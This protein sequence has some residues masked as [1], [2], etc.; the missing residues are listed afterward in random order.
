[1]LPHL[2]VIWDIIIYNLPM[3]QVTYF[4]FF[5]CGVN[6]NK[7]FLPMGVSNSP[8]IFQQRMNDNSK[9]LNLSART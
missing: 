9:D 5:L 7:K 4:Q 1:M 8:D 6:T 2:I 3:T